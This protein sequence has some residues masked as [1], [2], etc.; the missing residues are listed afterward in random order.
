MIFHR[1]V[2]MT[3][4]YVVKSGIARYLGGIKKQFQIHHVVDNNGTFPVFFRIGIPRL[5][6]SGTGFIACDE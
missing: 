1:L 6:D 4:G 5:D 2:G 3:D